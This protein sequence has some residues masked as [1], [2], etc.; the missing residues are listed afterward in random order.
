MPRIDSDTLLGDII[1]TI[2]SSIAEELNPVNIAKEV[3][4]ELVELDPKVVVR[5]AIKELFK[6]R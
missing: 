6:K 5:N 4:P 2:V 3:A 1:D